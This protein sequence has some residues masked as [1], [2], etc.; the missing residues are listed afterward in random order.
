MRSKVTGSVV[1]FG[2]IEHI[3]DDA[4]Y[5]AEIRR[6]LRPGRPSL[7]S[8]PNRLATS[9]QG[10][11]TN[12]FHVRDYFP[13]EIERLVSTAGFDHI[14]EFGQGQAPHR[15]AKL[16]ALKFVTRFP[17]LCRPGRWWDVLPA[18]ARKCAR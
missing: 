9:P 18:A 15:L 5:L 12:P 3:D 13:D 4:A 7:L 14:E 2:T 11:P 10:Q 6:V 8:T 17:V 1:A 16:V